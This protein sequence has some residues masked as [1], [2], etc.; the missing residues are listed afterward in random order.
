MKGE[1]TGKK[2]KKSVE[3]R[4]HLHGGELM[5][6]TLKLNAEKQEVDLCV[7]PAAGGS[8]ASH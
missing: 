7:G 2:G 8:A 3:E 5:T 4:R 1:T 6:T